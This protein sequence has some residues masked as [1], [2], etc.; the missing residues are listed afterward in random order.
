ML[1]QL[2]PDCCEVSTPAK[3]NLFL[4]VSARRPDGYHELETLMVTI[5]LFDT[6]RFTQTQPGHPNLRNHW[7]VSRQQHATATSLPSGPDNLV[8]KAASLLLRETGLSKG[9]DIDL[10]KRIPLAAG[11]A[12]GSSDAAATLLGL[13]CLWGLGLSLSEL[14]ELGAKLGSDVPFFLAGT[15]AAICRGR[16]EIIEP[17]RFSTGLHFVIVKP[18]AGLSTAQVFQNCQPAQ[19]PKSAGELVRSLHC[20]DLG[21]AGTQMFNR[22][23]APA[24]QLCNQV[25]QLRDRFA[26][27]PVFGHLMSGSGTSYFGL[28]HNSQQARR[29]AGRLKST[30][31]GQV[32]AVQSC[33]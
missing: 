31:P 25:S 22:L 2:H 8:L 6:L 10:F 7:C 17:V 3:L 32:F 21:R 11:L 20:G 28:C 30:H 27:L 9:V 19:T 5:S 33:V 18:A 29:L 23:G 26:S 16:G 1:R 13:N 24:E 15:N 14:R 12:G 4:E